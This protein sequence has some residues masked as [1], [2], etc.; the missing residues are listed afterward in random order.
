MIRPVRGMKP[1]DVYALKGVSDPRLSPD[2]TTVAF[3]PNSPE[4]ASA[5]ADTLLDL[6]LG[7]IGGLAGAILTSRV[8]R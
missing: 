7:M 1:E 2:G 4:A 3:V 8:S 6:A 5:Y